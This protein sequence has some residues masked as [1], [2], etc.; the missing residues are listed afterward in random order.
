MIM[1]ADRIAPRRISSPR[2]QI[3]WI[4]SGEREERLRTLRCPRSMRLASSISP[5]RVSSGNRAH[6]PQVHAHRIVGLVAE[7]LD[8][9]EVANSSPLVELLVEFE[10]RLF[11]DLDA[12]GIEI[13]QQIIEFAAAVAISSGSRSLTSS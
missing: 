1:S 13:R 11:Q 9:L 7:V 6:L 3:S 5:S 10:L 8:Q 2:R 4:T 12:R